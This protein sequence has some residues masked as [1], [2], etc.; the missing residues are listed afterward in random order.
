MKTL[1]RVGCFLILLGSSAFATYAQTAVDPSSVISDPT[2]RYSDPSCPAGNF[3]IDLTYTGP[4]MSVPELTFLVPNP[5]GELPDPASYTCESNVFAACSPI[6]NS[7]SGSPPATELYGF[8]FYTPPG[9]T[10]PTFTTDELFIL[11]STAPIQLTLPPGSDL[12]CTPPSSCP[13]GEISLSPEPGLAP[14]Y[15]TG[16]VFLI[17]FT[18]KRFGATFRT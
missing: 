6:D 7:P 10:P 15:M 9:D 13:T 3:C 14:L 17:G 12:A 4:T 8:V 16:L 2:I 1:T 5:P 18:R 11:S